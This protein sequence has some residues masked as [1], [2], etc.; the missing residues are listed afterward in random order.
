LR[1]P[2]RF[3]YGLFNHKLFGLE[4]TWLIETGAILRSFVKPIL[5]QAIFIVKGKDRARLQP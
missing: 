5:S 2:G 4:R 3:L 1:S